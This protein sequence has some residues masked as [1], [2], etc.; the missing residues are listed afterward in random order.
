MK[1]SGPIF[2]RNFAV[3]FGIQAADRASLKA[4]YTQITLQ[5]D[6]L[7]NCRLTANEIDYQ[8]EMLAWVFVQ[9][10]KILLSVVDNLIRAD[11]LQ[12][13]APDQ[14]VIQTFMKPHSSS[15]EGFIMPIQQELKCITKPAC[16][17]N[18]Q[19]RV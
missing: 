9:L 12:R 7:K 4:S 1:T 14:W 11:T 10:C 3:K 19:G 15:W 6:S 5:Q 17:S 8:V 18:A 16:K 2:A 13:V